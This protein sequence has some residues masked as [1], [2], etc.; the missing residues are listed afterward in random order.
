[1]MKFAQRT[2]WTLKEN[3]LTQRLRR[4]R[5]SGEPILDLTESN[6]TRCGFAYPERKILS[7]LGCPADLSYVP[8][9]KGLLQ[10]REA[11]CRYYA[12]RQVSVEP[13][14]VFLTSSTSEAYSFLFR[15]LADPNER[16]L[17]PRPSYPLFDFLG[18]LNDLTVDYYPLIYDDGWRPDFEKF[19]TALDKPARALVLV[20]PNNP[21]GSFVKEADFLFLNALAVQKQVPIISDEVFV[22]YVFNKKTAGFSLIQGHDNL[23]FT[24]GGLSKALALPQMKISWILVN[25]PSR[26]V[27]KAS[28]RLEVIADTYLSVSTPVQNS[29]SRWLD[30]QPGIQK[31]VLTRVRSNRKKLMEGLEGMSGCRYLKADGGWN[32]VLRLPS[33]CRE[34]AFVLD[35]LEKDHVLVY[36]GYF[37][38]FAEESH[39]VISL[40]PAENVFQP[41]LERLKIRVHAW[42]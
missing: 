22:D 30:L 2:N 4:L 19:R 18:G 40:L 25:G 32:A 15:L 39:V 29:L 41:A 16:V 17:F 28:A 26:L 42:V 8:N 37:F 9:P 23:I 11:V 10:A 1:M 36:P 5:Q 13:E 38:D 21:T 31:A 7:A 6:P 27:K 24:L 3:K 33:S 34:E 20:N 35:L 12:R 14:Q